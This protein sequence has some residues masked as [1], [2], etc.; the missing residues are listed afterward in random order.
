M[1][2]KRFHSLSW[3]QSVLQEKVS[4][5]IYY[6]LRAILREALVMSTSDSAKTDT[7]SGYVIAVVV[8]LLLLGA[9]VLIAN[10]VIPNGR[11]GSSNASTHPT[12]TGAAHKDPAFTEPAKPLRSSTP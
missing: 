10:L 11:T 2:E 3:G 6:S 7:T 1:H 8:A 5:R 12:T 4:R 9:V